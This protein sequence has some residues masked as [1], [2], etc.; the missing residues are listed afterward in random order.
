MNLFVEYAHKYFKEIQNIR[1]E[2][3][4]YPE[5]AY[6]EYQTSELIKSVLTNLKI[7]YESVGTTGVVG[8]I[9]G[10][11]PGKTILLRADMDALNIQEE[12]DVEYKSQ[13]AHKM[14]A[15]AHDGHV[16]SVLGAAMILNEMKSN[17][18]G[19]IKLMFQPSE[20]AAPSGAKMMIDQGILKNPKVDVAVGMH[21]WGSLKEGQVGIKYNEMMASFTGFDLKIKGK[22]SHAAMPHLGID[23]IVIAGQVINNLQTIN[24]RLINPCDPLVLSITEIKGGD[25]YNVIPEYVTMKGTIRTFSNEI[26]DFVAKQMHNIIDAITK[27]YQGSYELIIDKDLPPLINNNEVTNLVSESIAMLVKA[28]DIIVLDEP[29]MGSEDFAYVANEIPSSFFFYGIAKEGEE[30]VHHHP[31]FAWDDKILIET[32]AILAKIAY[33]YLTK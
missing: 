1:R 19:N 11:K 33:D 14:H 15:C 9:K 23:P 17:F 30:I 8:L 31:K 26:T 22:G 32:S 2:I 16:A 6:E 7:P 3:H 29:S 25:S 24:S 27:Q 5:T 12:V 4:R 20:E 10:A 28:E 18:Q 21:L 13:V